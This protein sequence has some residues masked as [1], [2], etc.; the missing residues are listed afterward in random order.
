M[1]INVDRDQLA[2]YG[3]TV[4]DVESALRLQNVE[5]PAGW[6]ESASREFSVVSSTDLNTVSQFNDVVITNVEGYPVRIKDV[7][8]VSVLPL[9]E[10]ISARYNGMPSL[11]IGVVKQA[12]ANSLDLSV[13]VRKEVVL[14]NQT[15]PAGLELIVS[16]DSSV[17][18]EK[19]I[20]SV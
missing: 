11:N 10:R 20:E 2:A 3:L 12:T 8:D 1:R 14:I 9:S 7:A 5:I 4:H 16:Y 6:F 19:S 17:F 15:L 13:A 18:I